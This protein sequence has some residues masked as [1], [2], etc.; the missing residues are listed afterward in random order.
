MATLLNRLGFRSEFMHPGFDWFYNRQ[1]VYRHLGF[2]RLMF[3]DEFEGMPTRSGY[4]SEYAT[5]TRLLEMFSQHRENFPSQP[6]FHFCVTIQ[7]HGPYIDK[8]LWDE[9][10]ATVPNFNTTLDLLDADINA[11]SNYFHGIV[12]ADVELRRLTDYLNALPEPVVLVYYSDHLP[13]FNLRIYDALLPDVHVPGSFEDMT[14]L[15][16]VPFLIWFNHDALELYGVA[17][18]NELICSD[19]ELLFTASFLGAFVMEMLGFT[20]L[21]PF[22][23]FN[24]EVRRLFPV[25]TDVRSFTP[26]RLI[27]GYLNELELAPLFLYRNWSY[28]RIFD[29]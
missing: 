17:H 18:P 26:E 11:L 2:E 7:N 8:F 25:M 5:I 6:Y 19:E 9:D 20:N 23:D 14:R 10:P 29:E 3:L 27:S 22:W 21:S 24:T 15:F 16:T 28:F 4:V 12:D 1:N 13:A